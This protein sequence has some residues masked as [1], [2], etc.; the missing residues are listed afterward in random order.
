MREKEV[1]L[2]VMLILQGTYL[3]VKKPIL[4]TQTKEKCG[5]VFFWTL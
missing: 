3:K 2:L 1:T 4:D 5:A